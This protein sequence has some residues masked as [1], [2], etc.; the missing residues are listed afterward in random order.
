MLNQKYCKYSEFTSTIH[1]VEEPLKDSLAT[2]KPSEEQR[3]VEVIVEEASSRDTQEEE[4]MLH[5]ED[6]N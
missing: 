4:I 1:E 5:Q 3:V 2:L 6:T